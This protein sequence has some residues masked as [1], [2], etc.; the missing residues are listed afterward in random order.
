MA[1]DQDL[2]AL[3][4][5]KRRH[6]R[7]VDLDDV[8]GDVLEIRET[9]IAGAEI[10]DGAGDALIALRCS[11]TRRGMPMSAL[12]SVNSAEWPSAASCAAPSPA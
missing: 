5:V 8:C 2:V 6:E 4:A 10:V 3:K 12:F 1:H 11:N 9:R 7:P